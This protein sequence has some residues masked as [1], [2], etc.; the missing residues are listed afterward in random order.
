MRIVDRL[1]ALVWSLALMTGAVVLILEVV[2]HRI[3]ADPVLVNWPGIYRWARET[4]W[5]AA[6]VR[7]ASVLV[8]V[9]GVALVV[10]QL[11][12]RRPS[13]VSLDSGI[14]ATTATVARRGLARS[15]RSAV[16]D[17]DGV[18]DADVAVS[19]RRIRVRAR[20]RAVQPA[21]APTM[22]D[23]VTHAARQRLDA[24]RLKQPPTLSVRLSTKER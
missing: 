2:A 1:L 18:S 16:T 7:L 5:T 10:A 13:Q 8:A 22:R 24:V 9:V 12:P 6:A 20:I 4:S 15:V 3:G 23:T 11:K 19:R 21:A 14:D 17:V